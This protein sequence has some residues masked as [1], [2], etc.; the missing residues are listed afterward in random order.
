M[1]VHA[2]GGDRW[3]GGEGARERGHRWQG[4]KDAGRENKLHFSR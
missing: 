3:G 1:F 2:K 4:S